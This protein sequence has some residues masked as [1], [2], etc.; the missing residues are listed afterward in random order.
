MLSL[1][2]LVVSASAMAADARRCSVTCYVYFCRFFFAR[3]LPTAALS[4]GLYDMGLRFL[5]LVY[6]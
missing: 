4:D 5:A 1:L 6:V 3:W 2:V